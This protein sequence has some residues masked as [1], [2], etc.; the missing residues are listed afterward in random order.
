[1]V[2]NLPLSSMTRSKV[3]TAEPSPFNILEDPPGVD[4][5]FPR[6]GQTNYD[7]SDGEDSQA[8]DSM[9]DG[10]ESSTSDDEPSSQVLE[11]MAKFEESFK[12][13]AQQYR[14]IDRIGEGMPL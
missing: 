1:M 13:L 2:A 6:N 3:P 7:S 12:D 11:D 4:E 14:L 8:E 5:K 9:S 10:S